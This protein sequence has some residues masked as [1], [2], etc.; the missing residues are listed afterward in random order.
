MTTDA[1]TDLTHREFLRQLGPHSSH[2]GAPCGR[3]YIHEH[4]IRLSAGQRMESRTLA[5]LA[6]LMVVGGWW[7]ARLAP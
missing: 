2:D 3:D 7:S 4:V 6:R 5:K 1:A